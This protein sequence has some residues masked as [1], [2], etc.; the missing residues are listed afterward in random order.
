MLPSCPAATSISV[1]TC[2]ARRARAL[3]A[4]SERSALLIRTPFDASQGSPNGRSP[5]ELG[6]AGGPPA[7]GDN[8]YRSA[9]V[10]SRRTLTPRL[11][12]LCLMPPAGGPPALPGR[13]RRRLGQ[14]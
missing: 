11:Q 5:R 12:T 9:Q 8:F 7:A 13:L 4:V 10:A 2:I 6:S 14:Q 3:N 1:V